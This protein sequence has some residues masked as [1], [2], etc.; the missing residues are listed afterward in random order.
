MFINN[1]SSIHLLKFCKSTQSQTENVQ[2]E[3]HSDIIFVYT[4]YI[5]N[6][7]KMFIVWVTAKEKKIH[8]HTHTHTP[9]YTQRLYSGVIFFIGCETAGR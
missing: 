5:L 7:N 2:K 3:G 8:T 4:V 1:T 6:T 9:T